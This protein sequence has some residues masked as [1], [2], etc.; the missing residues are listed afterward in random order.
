MEKLVSLLTCI[1]T[2]MGGISTLVIAVIAYRK[3]G[4]KAQ[5]EKNISNLM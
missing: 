5:S 3:W 2:L 4:K 1:G